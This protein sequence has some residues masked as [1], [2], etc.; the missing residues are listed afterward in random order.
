MPGTDGQTLFILSF[1]KYFY[2][3]VQLRTIADITADIKDI[4]PKC[5]P[6]ILAVASRQDTFV[7]SAN[8]TS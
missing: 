3:P 7:L 8:S 5:S 4:E 6:T 1:T 2:K